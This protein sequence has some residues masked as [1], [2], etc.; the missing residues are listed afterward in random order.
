LEIHDVP[1]GHISMFHEPN[2]RVLAESLRPILA[3]S[4][5]KLENE[6]ASL[7]PGI[8]SQDKG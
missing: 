1:G 7:A 5:S 3:S 2:V 8:G 6:A 4:G